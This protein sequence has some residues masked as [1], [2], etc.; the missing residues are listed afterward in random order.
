MA[1]K[2]KMAKIHAIIG[3]LE[4]EWPC[5]RIAR[6]LGVDRETVTRYA[7]IWRNRSNPA[8]PTTGSGS[9]DIPKPAIPTAGSE[10]TDL[11]FPTSARPPGRISRCEPF[12]ETIESK[13]EQNLS[14]QRIFQDIVAEHGFTGSYSSVKRFVNRLGQKTP[15]PFGLPVRLRRNPARWS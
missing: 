13:L 4:Q 12:K 10:L 3:L 1:N 15:L 7:K 6:E 11:V 5:R 9:P 14:T 8:I 2:L